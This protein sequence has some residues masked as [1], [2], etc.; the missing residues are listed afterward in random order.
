M[1][2]FDASVNDSVT[3]EL[4]ANLQ[5]V[6]AAGDADADAAPT[7]TDDASMDVNEDEDATVELEPNLMGVL[8]ADELRV[9]A[10]QVEDEEEDVTVQLEG[11]LQELV[12]AASQ[13]VHAAPS[14]QVE[15][16]SPAPRSRR[17]SS[18][19]R[20]SASANPSPRSVRRRKSMLQ[21]ALTP[22]ELAPEP[23]EQEQEDEGLAQHL[24]LTASVLP[25][26]TASSVT[27]TPN[28]SSAD[29]LQEMRDD[30]VDETARGLDASTN[31]SASGI[32]IGAYASTQQ[33]PATQ[34]EAQ[35]LAPNSADVSALSTGSAYEDID[36]EISFRR[37]SSTA[38][39]AASSARNSLSS[40]SS[41]AKSTSKKGR[42]SSTGSR[43]SSRLSGASSLAEISMISSSANN[44]TT[45]SLAST[46]AEKAKDVVLAEQFTLNGDE[47]ANDIADVMADTSVA[48]SELEHSVSE[49]ASVVH[50]LQHSVSE[51]ASVVHELEHS[52]SEC[53]SKNNSII[54]A[55]EDTA[56]PGNASG[57][58]N[59]SVMNTTTNANTSVIGPLAS[60]FHKEEA[61]NPSTSSGTSAALM[62]ES[63]AR[64][65]DLLSRVKQLNSSARRASLVQLGGR[66]SMSTGPA[67]GLSSRY[68]ISGSVGVKRAHRPSLSMYNPAATAAA[69]A[70]AAEEVEAEAARNVRARIEEPAASASME[71]VEETVPEVVSEVVPEAVVVGSSS[72][73]MNSAVVNNASYCSVTRLSGARVNVTIVLSTFIQAHICFHLTRN[74]DAVGITNMEVELVNLAEAEAEVDRE[75]KLAYSYF[76]AVMCSDKYGGPLSESFLSQNVLVASDIPAALH[77][78]NGYVTT[79]RQLFASLNT[80]TSI[81]SPAPGLENVT[82]DVVDLS[83]NRPVVSFMR[84]VAAADEAAT[85]PLAMLIANQANLEGYVSSVIN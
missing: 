5:D 77:T 33:E 24:N 78:I 57:Y 32:S 29:L 28:K 36:D 22:Q 64:V 40:T 53:A 56:A 68:S 19:R 66:A 9:A 46:P 83:A 62:D 80:M 75:S 25:P 63:A 17:N 73:A 52:V 60:T 31:T 47:I 27:S 71:I 13:A 58:H 49:C 18:S 76:S 67:A 50:E 69:A 70:A 74:G 8:Q 14:T 37:A 61:S 16:E 4:E 15:V 85:V 21:P 34:T 23:E 10:T 51:C 42:R 3:V 44:S 72:A 1:A 82:W 84:G 81:L 35:T 30:S 38:S 39:S 45:S 6:I 20:N 41:A 11:N 12:A 65:T 26:T 54:I 2:G 79:F 55:S 7:Q 43:H 59:T 48:V